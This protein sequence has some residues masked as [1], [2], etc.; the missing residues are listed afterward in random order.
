MRNLLI[1]SSSSGIG[2][3]LASRLPG[4]NP[5]GSA[6]WQDPKIESANH[7]NWDA[8]KAALSEETNEN[9]Y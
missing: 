6:E 2:K 4:Q 8:R 5:L 7:I 1:V 3:S 9:R